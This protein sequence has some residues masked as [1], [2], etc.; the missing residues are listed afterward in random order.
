[1]NQRTLLFGVVGLILVT[2]LW[3]LFLFS[4]KRSDV[5]DLR[6]EKENLEGQSSSLQA[7]KARLE[8]I[9]ENLLTFEVN[10]AELERSIPT[11]PDLATFLE[12]VNLLAQQ[13]SVDLL[14]IAPSLPSQTEGVPVLEIQVSMAIEGQFF[15]I[16]G[17]IYGLSD[18]E[19][20]VRIDTLALSSTLDE[21]GTVLL[22]ASLDTRLFTFADQVPQADFE[23]SGDGGVDEDPTS[24]GATN[25]G[26]TDQ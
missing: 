25:D 9:E 22:S 4:P 24:D 10:I 21:D 11:T 3:W 14:S 1:M 15:E 19:R 2:L 23:G 18:M 16:L 26:A 20:L 12:D 7:E 13:T 17:F 6:A 5:S 8:E